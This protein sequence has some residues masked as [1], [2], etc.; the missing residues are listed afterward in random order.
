[1]RK[2]YFIFCIIWMT[3]LFTISTCLLTS[4]HLAPGEVKH[5][6]SDI[7]LQPSE[8]SFYHWVKGYLTPDGF[9]KDQEMIDSGGNYTPTTLAH[10][11]NMALG[12]LCAI[13]QNDKIT[14]QLIGDKLQALYERDF[15]A[16]PKGLYD[17]YFTDTGLPDYSSDRYVGNN[18]WVLLFLD[19]YQRTYNNNRYNTMANGIASWLVELQD[20]PG[21]TYHYGDNGVYSGYYGAQGSKQYQAI[22]GTSNTI[23][24]APD[25][26]IQPDHYAGRT[27]TIISGTGSEQTR[28]IASHTTSVFTTSTDWTTIPDATSVFTI[29]NSNLLIPYKLAE[30]NIDTVAAL[31]NYA[32]YYGGTYA[33]PPITIEAFLLNSST[34]LYHPANTLYS[35]KVD[36]TNPPGDAAY[37]SAT[38]FLDI[39]LWA[40]LETTNVSDYKSFLHA[41]PAVNS[42]MS[43]ARVTP[44]LYPTLELTGYQDD[45]SHARIFI[46]GLAYFALVHYKQ[47]VYSLNASNSAANASA[48]LQQRNDNLHNLL[49]M[50]R[51][52]ITVAGT[53]G[54]PLYTN[55]STYRYSTY[56]IV[57]ES[58][59]WAILAL[60]NFNPFDYTIG[61]ATSRMAS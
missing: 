54:V 24:I 26:F 53:E 9:L 21:G 40:L 18:A 11:Y 8:T 56:S 50:A 25:L 29:D 39:H 57:S 51:K 41:L 23:T 30:G 37:L 3:I 48:F 52:S 42:T 4:A 59:C 47:Y 34:G 49:L 60:A 16:G 6:K 14:A 35:G 20:T 12:G 33:T 46:E 44:D 22:G 2:K 43:I 45:T 27:I 55:L 36:G 28:V 7:S 17:A 10:I 1:M 38:D 58:T 31:R 5:E 13:S 19:A 61:N 32:I 15:N